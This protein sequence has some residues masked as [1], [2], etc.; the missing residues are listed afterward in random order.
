MVAVIVVTGYLSASRANRETFPNVTIPT[1]MVTATLPGASARD[2]ETKIA[3]PIQEAVEDLDGV[4]SFHSVVTDNTAI[5]TV[6]L[7]D[8]LSDSRILEA[9]RDLSVL[10][11]AI[12]DFPPEME[13]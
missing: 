12:K 7:Y 6:E 3:I 8:G 11:D 2:V 13:D 9:E 5:T 1:L 4:K 10:L